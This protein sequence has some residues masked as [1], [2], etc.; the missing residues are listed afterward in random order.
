MSLRG[1]RHRLHS[2][3]SALYKLGKQVSPTFGR[4]TGNLFSLGEV[5]PRRSLSPSAA[6]ALHI[7]ITRH[8]SCNSQSSLQECTAHNIHISLVAVRTLRF[9]RHFLKSK[10][11]IAHFTFQKVSTLAQ[12][13]AYIYPDIHRI[14][15]ARKLAINIWFILYR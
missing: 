5:S 4:P 8:H 10:T 6:S 14:F 12:F 13:Y 1:Q 11:R 15:I 9:L 2:Q 7:N 3:C